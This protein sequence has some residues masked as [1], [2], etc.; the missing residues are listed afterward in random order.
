MVIIKSTKIEQQEKAFSVETK[1][2]VIRR[3]DTGE[4]RSQMGA[5]LN[6]ETS[7]M[8]TIL[9]NK[10]KNTVLGNCNYDKLCSWNYPF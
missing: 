4:R 3:L 2:Q 6:L 8:R 9:K 7:T 5:A 10:E 1:M